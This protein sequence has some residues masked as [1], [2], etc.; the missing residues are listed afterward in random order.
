MNPLWSWPLAALSLT[1]AWLM[2]SKHPTAWPITLVVNTIGAGYFAATGQPGLVA[3][4]AAFVVLN[5]RGWLRWRSTRPG[6]RHHADRTPD[7]LDDLLA[8]HAPG[9]AR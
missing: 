2:G 1:A 6:P 8:F 7:P 3:L 9:R 4:E 5:V